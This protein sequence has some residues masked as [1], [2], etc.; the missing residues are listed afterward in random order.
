LNQIGTTNTKSLGVLG[1]SKDGVGV[2][3][4]TY[5]TVFH[6]VEGENLGG[7]SG[8][9]VFGRSLGGGAGVYG[10]GVGTALAATFI[11]NVSISGTV[12]A[13]GKA[14]LI[15]HPCSPEERL[16]RHWATESN[17]ML[18]SYSGNTVTDHDGS[19]T[20]ELE[21]YVE[22]LAHDFRYQLTPI[23]TLART[24]VQEEI[25]DGKFTIRTDAPNVKVSWFLQGVRK[26]AYAVYSKSPVEQEKPKHWKGKYITP[27]AHGA[28]AE[29]AIGR[30]EGA[31][32]TGEPLSSG[33]PI[34]SVKPARP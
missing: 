5:S 4:A 30:L 7:G 27:E 33:A 11:G 16:L 22:S 29:Q 9:G 18:V 6:G 15:D 34:S 25:S 23:G 20:I 2:G 14:F 28:R 26:D 32:E 31:L 3:G 17:E 24:C 13:A 21:G 10:E 19:A 1:G 12:A 8:A